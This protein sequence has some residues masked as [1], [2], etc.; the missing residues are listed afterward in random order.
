MLPSANDPLRSAAPRQVRTPVPHDVERAWRAVSDHLRPT[1]LEFGAGGRSASDFALKLESLQPTGSFKVRGALSALSALDGR[2]RV[3][4]ASAGNHGLGVAF[5]A[6]VLGRP[7]TV[8]VAENASP[9]KVAKLRRFGVDLVQAGTSY[10]EAEAHALE[11][12]G[13]GAHYLSS[14]N[15]P[16]VIAGQG[17]MGFELDNQLGGRGN[18]L[19]V[20]C[21]IGGGGLAAGLGLWASARPGVRVVGVETEVSTAVS[22]A[23]SAGRQV[24]VEVGESIADGMAGNIEAG[25]VTPGLIGRYVDDL[26]T[27]SEAE[28]RGAVRHLALERGFVAEG[29]GA[30]AAAALLAGKVRT[31]GLAVAVVSGRNITGPTLTA[32]LG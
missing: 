18:G 14:Y 3:V 2:T 21:A 9:A 28:I 31:R 1:P 11:L 10:D 12:A 4:T 32:A 27:V 15:D 29:A 8:V 23:I 7:A 25:A 19:T 22:A 30:A 5:A 20:V 16:H 13:D 26:V 6:R 17:T 24:T